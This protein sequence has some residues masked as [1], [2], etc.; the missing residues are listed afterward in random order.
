MTPAEFELVKRIVDDLTDRV[1][2]IE[3]KAIQLESLVQSEYQINREDIATLVSKFDR[4]THSLL[5]PGSNSTGT[6]EIGP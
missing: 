1:K 5:S 6:P 4:H 3:I 2:V